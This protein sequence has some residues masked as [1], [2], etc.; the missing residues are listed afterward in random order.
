[1]DNPSNPFEYSPAKNQFRHASHLASF[2]H[3]LSSPAPMFKNERGYTPWPD[4]AYANQANGRWLYLN[5]PRIRPPP[6]N[7]RKLIM[8]QCPME[9]S[10]C[11]WDIERFEDQGVLPPNPALS[12]STDF[13][14][15]W[16]IC[17]KDVCD[18][19]GHGKGKSRNGVN[20][21]QLVVFTLLVGLMAFT[22]KQTCV[23]M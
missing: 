15:G 3:A 10:Y 5:D 19:Y 12:L 22:I 11:M 6:V 2:T 7:R 14:P 16:W 23:L 8:V 17:I 4:S 1:M 21:E 13:N 20:Q 18:A 9:W